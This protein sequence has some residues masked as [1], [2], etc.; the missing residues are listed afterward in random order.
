MFC[1]IFRSP[2][3][4]QSNLLELWF[5]YWYE[6]CMIY[7]LKMK[8]S[9]FSLFWKCKARGSSCS[10]LI[11][12]AIFVWTIN[13]LQILILKTQIEQLKAAVS[14]RIIVDN[15]FATASDTVA[16]GHNFIYSSSIG[17]GGSK[18]SWVQKITLKNLMKCIRFRVYLLLIVIKRVN[19]INFLSPK[20]PV[21]LH[22]KKP[23]KINF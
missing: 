18:T 22:F 9:N 8:I 4:Y 6:D 1:W 12:A 7:F 23:S 19:F 11:E 3:Q 15:N 2:L 17:A 13:I 10:V 21:T 16:K 5:D 14:L 20:C